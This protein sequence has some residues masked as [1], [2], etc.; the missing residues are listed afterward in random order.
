[1]AMTLEQ[2]EQHDLETLKQLKDKS[3]FQEPFGVSR[4]QRYL[5]IGYNRAARTIEAGLKDGVLVHCE[6]TPYAV[7]FKNQASAA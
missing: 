1:M 5:K 7:K 2:Y 4:L 3:E 6:N